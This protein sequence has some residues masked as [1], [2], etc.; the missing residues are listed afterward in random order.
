VL[1]SAL[2]RGASLHV[3]MQRAAIAGSLACT[4]VGALLSFPSRAQIDAAL[5]ETESGP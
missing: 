1:A 5:L 4:V 3:A 2:A